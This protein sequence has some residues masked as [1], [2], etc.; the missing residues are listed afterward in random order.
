M[1]ARQIQSTAFLFLMYGIFRKLG[2]SMSSH[3]FFA[4][5]LSISRLVGAERH[6]ILKL[7]ATRSSVLEKLMYKCM[8]VFTL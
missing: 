7:L 3:I 6:C 2:M 4:W 8:A 1:V 5:A